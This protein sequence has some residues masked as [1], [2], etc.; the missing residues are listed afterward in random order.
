[1]RISDWSSD[2]CSSDLQERWQGARKARLDTRSRVRRREQNLH[3]VRAEP[4]HD[5]GPAAV[6][7]RRQES[8]RACELSRAGPLLRRRSAYHRRRASPWREEAANRAD[9]AQNP[10]ALDQDRKSVVEEKRGPN[11]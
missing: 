1:M 4:W 3:P 10:E 11:G 9:H 8:G 5:R 2:V 7:D 6:R